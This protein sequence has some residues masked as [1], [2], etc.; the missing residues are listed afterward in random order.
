MGNVFMC[1]EV[2]RHSII[3]NFGIDIGQYGNRWEDVFIKNIDFST[4]D[5]ADDWSY[6]FRDSKAYDIDL[7]AMDSSEVT[8]MDHMFEG[9]NCGTLHLAG[10]TIGEEVSAE[11]IFSGTFDSIDFTNAKFYSLP[12]NMFNG[13]VVRNGIQLRTLDTSRLTSLSGMFSNSEIAAVDLTGLDTSNITDMSNMFY[14]A[15][16]PVL[17]GLKT[18]DYSKVTN[19]SNMFSSAS[20]ASLD[21]SG[22][23]FASLQD[24]SYMFCNVRTGDSNILTINLSNCRFPSITN[25]YEMFYDYNKKSHLILTGSTFISNGLNAGN[26]FQYRNEP[27][28]LDLSGFEG[29]KINGCYSMFSDCVLGLTDFSVLDFS[30]MTSNDWVFQRC[31]TPEIH[32]STRLPNDVTSYYSWYITYGA[33]ADDYIF[34]LVFPFNN[35]S[36]GYLFY[37]DKEGSTFLVDNSE[38]Y[39]TGLRYFGY[40]RENTDIT[41]EDSVLHIGD[42]GDLGNMLY[43]MP[44]SSTID[45]GGLVVDGTATS[46]SYFMC[47][48]SPREITLPDT[49]IK[50]TGE[51]YYFL[52]GTTRWNSETQRSEPYDIVVNNLDKLDVRGIASMYE[53]FYYLDGTFDV[54]DWNTESLTR[55]QYLIS[56]SCGNYNL[57]NW[58]TENVTYINSIVNSSH[59]YFDLRNWDLSNLTYLYGIGLDGYENSYID[60]DGWKVSPDLQVSNFYVLSA[61]GGYTSSTLNH[62]IYLPNTLYQPTSYQSNS[63]GCSEGVIIDVYT[64]ASSIEEQGWQFSHIYTESEPYGYRIHLNTTHNDFLNAVGGD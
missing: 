15:N 22:I 29:V 6:L 46:S 45:M 58:N 32:L 41:I 14:Y 7:G 37:G 43:N 12:A 50:F 35:S 39:A 16:I 60:L 63:F 59:G 53:L 4:M 11:N 48:G 23:N 62:I 40:C 38:I 33:K 21:L 13:A 8:N 61:Y 9:V 57:S 42:H 5:D 1:Q 26:M 52:Y 47:Y 36:L 64:N 51:F 2:H 28:G 54:S 27:N 19:A 17:L 25:A 3:P 55:M 10:L 24:A 44:H 20:L 30:E 34:E 49:G 31:E 56:S 18:L